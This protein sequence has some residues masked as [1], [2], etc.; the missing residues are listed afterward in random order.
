MRTDE[1]FEPA[2]HAGTA[3]PR[4][5]AA[6]VPPSPVRGGL[7]VDLR[8]TLPGEVAL[9]A[10]ADHCLKIHAGEPVRGACLH[11]RFVVTRG[12]VDILPAG[13]SDTWREED[14][15]TSVLLRLSPALLRRAAEDRGHDPDRVAL[16]PRFQ[17]RDVSIEHIAW[18]LDAERRADYPSG[19]LYVESLGL[20]L[21][22][23]LLGRYEPPPRV[24]RGLSKRQ[25]RR[26]VSY[27]D[28]HLGEELSLVTLAEVAEV[29]PSHFKTLFRRSLGMPAHQYVIR[30]RV[31][32]AQALLARGDRSI[33][34]VA[35][36]SGFAHQSHLARC[37]RRVLGVTPAALR[38]RR[39]AP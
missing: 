30:R 17:V 22:A 21:A 6:P 1:A 3:P 31:E 9:T 29:S 26:V 23:H 37:M 25:A 38:A 18:A 24:E 10:G 13:T 20:A 14:A 33:A 16:E 19:T 35:L 11:H 2:F 7:R 8:T 27:I 5:H 34:Q 32:R 28:A 36:E 12:D 39:D 15:S 4:R